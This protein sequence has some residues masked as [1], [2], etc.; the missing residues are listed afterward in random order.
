V[1]G[2]YVFVRPENP[3]ALIELHTERTP[4]LLS[5]VRFPVE[6]FLCKRK[7]SLLLDR[8]AGS[9]AL[10]PKTEFVLVS[11]HGAKHF[12]E[13]LMWVSDIL[14]AFRSLTVPEL[15]WESVYAS[16]RIRGRKRSEMVQRSRC[17]LAKR[18]ACRRRYRKR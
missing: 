8:H 16:S 9:R 13:R 6:K 4:P 10:L 17:F 5:L 1:P 14:P 11:I 15:D 3:I 2:Q 12:W 7:V 18:P